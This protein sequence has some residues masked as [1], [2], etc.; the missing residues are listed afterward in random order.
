MFYTILSGATTMYLY[1]FFIYTPLYKFLYGNNEEVVNETPI[2]LN[3]MD[4]INQVGLVGRYDAG[5]TST[6]W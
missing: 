3:L 5:H 6:E 2:R 1:C 4:P